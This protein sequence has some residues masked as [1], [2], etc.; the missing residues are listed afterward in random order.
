MVLDINTN[1]D[2]MKLTILI[3]SYSSIVFIK[4]IHFQINK[5][6]KITIQ[7]VLQDC[8]PSPKQNIEL[9]FIIRYVTSPY[10]PLFSPLSECN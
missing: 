6:I 5:S 8:K 4:I 10:T 9:I 2:F 1:Y 3:L 7:L